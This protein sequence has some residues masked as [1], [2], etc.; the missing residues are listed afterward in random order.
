MTVWK[1]KLIFSKVKD[2]FGGRIRNFISGGAPLSK[3]LA[4]FFGSLELTILEGYGL[5]ET[6]PIISCNRPDSYKFG[7]VGKPLDNVEV[8]IAEDGEILSRGPNIMS[9]YFNK[10]KETQ[11]AID[12]DGWFHTGDIGEID[13]EG[14]LKITDRKKSLIVTSGGKNVAPAPIENAIL[15]SVYVEQCIVVGDRRNFIS[16][17]IVPNFEALSNYLLKQD[18][19]LSGNQAIAEHKKTLSLLDNVIDKAMENFSKFE[20][21]KKYRVLPNLWTLEKGELTPSLKTVRRI[22]EENYKET[23]DS[24]YSSDN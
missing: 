22:I 16:C 21:V 20:T 3:E 8:R 1:K 14:F 4:E 19:D 2:N 18:V 23:I 6:S 5:T 15:N 13:S 12:Q 9:G 10:D 7:T 11:E 24:M 17:L